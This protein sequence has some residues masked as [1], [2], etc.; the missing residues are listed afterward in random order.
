MLGRRTGAAEEV[1]QGLGNFERGMQ[2]DNT[3]KD[4]RGTRG[5]VNISEEVDV[6]IWYACPSTR[7]SE[8]DC[9]AHRGLTYGIGNDSG[10]G[11]P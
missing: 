10:T 5:A 8:A 2:E 7:S 9:K 11:K 6:G 3:A 1:F 4:E